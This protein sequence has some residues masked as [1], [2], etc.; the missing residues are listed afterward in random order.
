MLQRFKLAHEL[1]SSA[2]EQVCYEVV[3]PLDAEP[4]ADH[5]AILQLDPEG[6]AAV[7]WAERKNK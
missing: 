5:D 3:M 6:H 7:E 1:L 4:R 2:D